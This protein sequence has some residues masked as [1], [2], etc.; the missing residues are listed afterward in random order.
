MELVAWSEEGI[1]EIHLRK[2]VGSSVPIDKEV[3]VSKKY[4][5]YSQS[6]S[7]ELFSTQLLSTVDSVQQLYL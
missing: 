6:D 4:M 1:K 3:M 2:H 7:A 5:L